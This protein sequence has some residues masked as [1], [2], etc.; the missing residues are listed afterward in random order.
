MPKSSELCIIPRCENKRHCRGVCVACYFEARR[1][2]KAKIT[3]DA[4]LVRRKR[5]L[6]ANRTGR[7]SKNKLRQ[8]MIRKPAKAGA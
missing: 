3:T 1:L 7:P 4:E 2:I 8:L 5:W 6:P